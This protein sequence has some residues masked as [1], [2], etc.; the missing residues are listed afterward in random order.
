[1]ITEWGKSDVP[2]GR[3]ELGAALRDRRA[4][5]LA[6]YA[7]IPES[8]W[9]PSRFPCLD[10]VNPPLWEVAHIGWFAEFFGLRWA[11]HDPAGRGRPS[12][13]DGADALLDSRGIA[14]AER[15]SRDYPDR[16]FL[17]D[18]LAATL[19]ALLE[20]L[21]SCSEQQLERIRLALVHEDMH[22]EAFLMTLQTLGLP[23]PAGFS[24]APMGGCGEDLH[25]EGGAIEMGRSDRHFRF[26]NETPA[27]RVGVEPFSIAP[28]PVA[29]EELQ[30]FRAS[31]RYRDAELWGDEGAAWL[32]RQPVF[33]GQTEG[34]AAMHVSW[35]EARAFCRHVQRRLP[36]EAEWE[37]AA[38]HSA[39]FRASC[40]QV[41]E[42]TTTPFGP[43]PG[44]EPGPYADYSSPW[45][46]DHTVLKG[47][48]FAT[49][50]RLRYPQYRNF[51]VPGRS[52]MF[53]GFRTCA[54]K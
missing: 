25:F 13:W 32:A 36:S 3:G 41:W 16:R 1:M 9:V 37:F 6:I 15:W 24:R 20:V 22:A 31:P 38:V 23:L 30:A 28:Q 8:F 17:F 2:L 26:D 18:Y 12:I 45:F 10:I 40:G 5:T 44:F 29:A 49:E 48:S 46:G 33:R 51:Y 11:P 34:H 39:R 27:M 7:E 43:Y 52:D 50:P 19:D 14:H 21:D 42:W 47:G 53:C 54:L 35:F 4:R